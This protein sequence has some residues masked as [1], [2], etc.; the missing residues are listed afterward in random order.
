MPWMKYNTYKSRYAVPFKSS[1]CSINKTLRY[2]IDQWQE[3][4]CNSDDK[5]HVG[6]WLDDKAYTFKAFIKLWLQ[7]EYW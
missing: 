2:Q 5:L 4:R 6:A 1:K 7:L 3:C